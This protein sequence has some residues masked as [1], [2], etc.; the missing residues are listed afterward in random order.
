[1]SPRMAEGTTWQEWVATSVGSVLAVGVIVLLILLT[2]PRA[3][4]AV[5]F[6]GLALF[7]IAGVMFVLHG[8]MLIVPRRRKGWGYTGVL[9]DT[10]LY[11]VVRHP[12][13]LGVIVVFVGAVLL[14]QSWPVCAVA[15]VGIAVMY[16]NMVLEERW[17]RRRFG[18]DYVS[19]MQRVPRV[20]IFAG[21]VRAVRRRVAG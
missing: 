2:N 17:N 4:A 8:Y 20:N 16:W 5:Q 3:V 10:G 1:M 14:G 13:Y 9:V 21:I 6:A 11:G 7:A 15:V 12:L 18:E 19:Y